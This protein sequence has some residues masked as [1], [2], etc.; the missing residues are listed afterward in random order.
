MGW[1][2]RFWACLLLLLN[3]KLQ[4]VVGDAED[5]WEDPSYLQCGL[6]DMQ[7][8]LPFLIRD[9]AFVLTAIDTNGK[10]HYLHNNSACGTWVGQEPDGSVVVGAAYDGCFVNKQDGEYLMTVSLEE[11]VDGMVHYNKK[12]LKC[13]VLPVMDAPSQSVC[14]SVSREDK[15][16]CA[17]PVVSRDL[18]ESVGCCFNPTDSTIPC[19]YGNKL[20]AQ[21]AE[22][23]TVALSKELTLPSLILDSVLVAGI[24]SISCPLLN[25][26]KSRSFIVFQ[27]P[28]S[29]G[30]MHQVDDRT[31]LY[32]S[33]IEAHQDI[34]SLHR[35]SITRDSTTRV[36]VRCS[37]SRTAVLPVKVEVFT[38][39]PPSPVSS[40]GPLFLEMRIAKDLQYSSYYGDGDYPVVRVLREPV[41]LEVRILQRTDPGLVLILKDC[42][43]NPS[44]DETPQPQWP[45]LVSSCPFPGDNYLTQLILVAPSQSLP[46]PS[47]YKRF[48]ISTF[49]FVDGQ[50]Q[51]SLGG[52][53]YFHCSA[54]VCVPSPGNPCRTTCG[55]R[56]KR[57][58]SWDHESQT[59]VTSG[60]VNFIT[61]ENTSEWDYEPIEQIISGVS[62]EIEQAIAADHSPTN[63]T[64]QL[65]D[66]S[67]EPELI[68]DQHDAGIPVSL[69]S[70]DVE[71]E[72][73]VTHKEVLRAGSF[74]RTDTSPGDFFGVARLA[75]KYLEPVM[76]GSGYSEDSSTLK[77][78][79][80][81]V[82]VGGIL[83][84]TLTVLSLW[85][86]HRNHNTKAYPVKD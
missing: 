25:V 14:S 81:A 80:G 41:Y 10:S 4:C 11:V 57:Q 30:V 44:P 82:A 18:C 17:S 7:F 36:T 49:T 15:L 56:K 79:R 27:Y 20:T 37:Y 77:W 84:V 51:L 63:N 54:S 64:E 85:R 73:S 3:S 21:C 75:P 9:S 23:I 48:S 24:N 76:Q 58:S 83:A 47:H 26:Q 55:Q 34:R 45:I 19:Y 65:V 86:C 69:T 22:T 5:F 12:D 52:L 78:L 40:T 46:L 43:A 2:A 60:P 61:I 39:P 16:P 67:V 38:L 42:W 68:T 28:L 74:H 72:E 71:S 32:E 62:A 70:E 66:S 1:D 50:T 31:M 6:T 59:I 8:F 33:T 29:C 13:P 53:V 35:A